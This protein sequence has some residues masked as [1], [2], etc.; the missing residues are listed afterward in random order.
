MNLARELEAVLVD[1]D[2][3]TGDVPVGDGP[4]IHDVLAG[5]VSPVAAVDGRDSIRVLPSGRTLAGARAVDLSRLPAVLRVLERE[6]GRVVIDCPAGLARDVGHQ[7]SSATVAVL[8][9]TLDQAAV[10]DAIRTEEL[11][12]DLE[13]PVGTVVLNRVSRDGVPETAV[14]RIEASFGAPVATLSTQP[15]I[16]AALERG[17]P[18][19]DV[20]PS[21]SATD[22]FAKI[23]RRISGIGC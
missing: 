16:A 4:S 21:S 18:V 11:A 12:S 7:L 10:V 19:R 1:G 14:N 5:R 20:A 8:V 6:Y 2:F 13:T 15:T 17:K 3:A 22:S 23:A 9:T